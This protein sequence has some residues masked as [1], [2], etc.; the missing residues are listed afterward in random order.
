[1][2]YISLEKTIDRS[3]FNYKS[4]VH[5][6]TKC[7]GYLFG[8]SSSCYRPLMLILYLRKHFGYFM[9]DKYIFPVLL[10]ELS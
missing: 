2:G 7:L 9:L 5:S 8:I 1:M 4:I 3:H 6:H 10:E